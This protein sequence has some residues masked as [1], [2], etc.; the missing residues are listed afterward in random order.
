MAG[1][2][3][4]AGSTHLRVFEV[5]AITAAGAIAPRG[6]SI[7]DAAPPSVSSEAQ[8]GKVSVVWKR[9]FGRPDESRRPR[10]RVAP[11]TRIYAI[12]D[13]HG[14]ADLLE[15]MLLK[16]DAD[17]KDHPDRRCIT[18]LLGDYVD[19]GPDS[20]GVIDLLIAWQK[21][22]ETVCLMGNHEEI[23]LRFFAKPE[24]WDTWAPIG[25]AQT[26]MS[27]GLRP[28]LRLSPQQAAELAD[29]L[30]EQIPDAHVDFLGSLPYTFESGDVL[31]VHAGL[32][33][34]RPVADQRVEDLLWIREEFLSFKGSFGKLVVHGHTPVD[35]PDI[36]PNR[37]NIDTGAYATGRLCCLVLQDGGITFL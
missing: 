35:K 11:G 5:A 17:M 10:P 2:R 14:R 8:K 24:L 37:I 19:R 25:G 13:I 23:M 34:G 12:G 36:Q 18:V 20:R 31:F 26:V 33:P 4:V 32:K 6:D 29:R 3:R 30:A 7:K 21:V 22:R 28:A 15:Q 16:V 27:Y 9:I 1:W